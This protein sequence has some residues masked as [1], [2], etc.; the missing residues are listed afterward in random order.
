MWTASNQIKD[1]MAVTTQFIDDLWVL[2]S[3]LVRFI[4]VHA[5]HTSEDISDCLYECLL[6]WNLDRKLST[7]I[8]DNFT[9]KTE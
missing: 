9:T 6:Y 3:R 5:P 7:L 1:Y 8:V 4:Y 2:Q